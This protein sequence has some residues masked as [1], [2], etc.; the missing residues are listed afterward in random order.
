MALVSRVVCRAML[1]RDAGSFLRVGVNRSGCKAASSAFRASLV[2]VLRYAASAS[3]DRCIA[4]IPA[5]IAFDMI[6]ADVVRQEIGG[7][8]NGGQAIGEL[9]NLERAVIVAGAAALVR[10]T[11]AAAPHHRA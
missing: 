1:Q 8:D 11:P 3:S 2:D 9:G 4:A 5:S 6:A 10:S 7:P